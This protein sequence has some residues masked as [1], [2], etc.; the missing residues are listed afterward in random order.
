MSDVQDE[1]S[2]L[3]ERMMTMEHK[4]FDNN[5]ICPLCGKRHCIGE[6]QKYCQHVSACE[7]EEFD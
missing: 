6:I 3:N 7:H 2:E 1:A 4:P 5:L